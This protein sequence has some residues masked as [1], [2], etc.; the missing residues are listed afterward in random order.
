MISPRLIPRE[1][2]ERRLRDEF[3]C[4]KL[5]GDAEPGLETGEWWLTQHDF[6]LPVACDDAGYLRADDWQ[7]VLILIARLKPMDWDT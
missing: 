4:K 2:W 3:L 7:S 1:E 5:E 6:L